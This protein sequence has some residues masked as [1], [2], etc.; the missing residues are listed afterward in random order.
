[1][2]QLPPLPSDLLVSL[3]GY[4][5]SEETL[6]CSDAAV[7]RLCAPNRPPLIA[8]LSAAA[9]SADRREEATRV[10]WLKGV[11]ILAPHVIHVAEARDYFWLVMECLSGEDATKSRAPPAVKTRELAKA[12]KAI[13]RLDPNACPFDETLAVKLARAAN[14]LKANDVNED[15]FDDENRGKTAAELYRQ[16]ERLC[17]ATEDVVVAHGDACLPNVMLDGGRFSGFVDCGRLGRSD[18]YQDLALACR[19]IAANLG[20]GW[21]GVFLREYGVTTIDEDRIRFYRLLDEFF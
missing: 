6:G 13:H 12:L 21:I 11:G 9:K 10:K 17:P 4:E 19:S 5:A 20:S 16:L 15:D 14:R 7:F 2:Q 3:D 8:K 18:R 1:M